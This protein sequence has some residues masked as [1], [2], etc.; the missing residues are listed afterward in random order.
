MAPPRCQLP[1]ALTLQVSVITVRQVIDHNHHNM[2]NVLFI[3]N[4]N[5]SFIYLTIILCAVA[6]RAN[7]LKVS[8]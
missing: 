2:A 6:Q 3:D 7:W 4:A 1:E 5:F 8:F